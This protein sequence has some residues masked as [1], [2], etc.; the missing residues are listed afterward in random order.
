MFLSTLW[1]GSWPPSPG[2][3]PL[4]H[5]DLEV[6][7]IDQIF[8]GHAEAARRHLLDGGAHGIAIGERLEALGL[9]AAF[10]GVGAR[11]DAVHGDREIGVRLARDRAE[12]HRAGGEALD[13][14]DRRLDLVERDRLFRQLELHQPA[15]GQQPLALLVD[16]V[17]EQAVFGQV[18][19]AHRMLQPRHRVRRP[20]VLLAAQAVGIVAADIEH[21]AIDR[22]VAIGVAVPRDALL[23][24]VLEPDAFESRRRA[25]E[26]FLDEGRGQPDRIENLR[27]AIGLVGRDAHLG[28]HLQHALADRLDVVLLHLGGLQIDPASARICSSVSNAI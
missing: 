17:G 4:R 9:L 8:R 12:A 7:G 23:G 16:R 3:A 10:A 19:A 1:P 6:V 21:V 15:Q 27:A 22:I 25:G 13:D 26:I 24:D 11:A 5:L 2:L 28:H 14:L 20:G 18:V